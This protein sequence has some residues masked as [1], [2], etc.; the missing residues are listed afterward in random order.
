LIAREGVGA[1]IGDWIPRQG[2]QTASDV[3]NF[4]ARMD[5]AVKSLRQLGFQTEAQ[6]LEDQANRAIMQVE[7]RQEF[8]LILDESNEYPRL[9][10]PDASTP[11]RELRDGI[12]R[13]DLLIKG[14]D[15]AAASTGGAVSPQ[16]AQARVKAIQ[17]RQ[18]RLQKVLDERRAALGKIYQ[19]PID[20]EQQLVATLA[21]LERLQRLFLDTPDEVD[22]IGLLRQLKRIQADLGAWETGDLSP[23]RLRTL[24]DQQIPA[25]IA[26]LSSELDAE[27]IEPAWDLA[28][29]YQALAS[30]RRVHQAKRS[31]DWLKPRLSLGDSLRI[32][33]RTECERLRAEL[34]NAPAYLSEAD[35][36]ELTRLLKLVKARIVEIDTEER[37][38]RLAAWRAQF[39]RQT[40]IATLDKHQTEAL[41]RALEQPPV[42]L[43]PAE[44]SELEPL[45]QALNE[46]FDNMST[47]DIL[48]RIQR[49]PIDR[50]RTIYQELARVLGISP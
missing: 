7:R 26:A 45:H 30:E 34:Q 43:T 29:L 36:G 38:C 8:R 39:P 20:S 11:V 14:V 44:Q 42:P 37:Q 49:L 22:I 10:D 46:H 41:L 40:D 21:H 27:E 9:P 33:G 12:Q 13:G 1:R 4:H 3:G 24:L 19:T 16:E 48:A 18:Q 47:S 32:S 50:Q 15:K 25:Q 28:G 23:E 35:C 5:K 6:A 17:A 2:C 31:A